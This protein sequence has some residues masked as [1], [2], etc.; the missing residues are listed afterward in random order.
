VLFD[1]RIGYIRIPRA[2]TRTYNT[3][4]ILLGRTQ[5]CFSQTYSIRLVSDVRPY[6]AYQEKNRLARCLGEKVWRYT[7]DEFDP[8]EIDRAAVL[9]FMHHWM[10]LL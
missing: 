1:D 7:T 5:S 4:Y 2:P 10:A 9:R 8:F 6:L 3:Y